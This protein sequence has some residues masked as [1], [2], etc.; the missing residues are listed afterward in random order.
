VRQNGSAWG[1]EKSRESDEASKGEDSGPG[2]GGEGFDG[3]ARD[4]GEKDCEKKDGQ[5][6]A[7]AAEG[8]GSKDEG[9]KTAEFHARVE[10]LQEALSEGSFLAETGVVQCGGE[11]F[12]TALY[13]AGAAASDGRGAQDI[14]CAQVRRLLKNLGEEIEP[15]MDTDG[16]GFSQ[17]SS[18]IVFL[19]RVYPGSSVVQFNSLSGD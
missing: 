16:H 11:A 19:I 13:E 5:G 17:R 3:N 4:G 8:D 15:R 10:A 18:T 9:E 12:H 1:N 7:Q 2:A 14:R 6:D